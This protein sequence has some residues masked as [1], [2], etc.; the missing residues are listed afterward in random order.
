MFFIIKIFIETCYKRE[1][2]ETCYHA[3]VFSLIENGQFSQ[4]R[5]QEVMKKMVPCELMSLCENYQFS[6]H[7]PQEVMQKIVPC[8][9][10]SSMKMANFLNIAPER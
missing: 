8:E 1:K 6:Q 3:N 4:H 5:P 2:E 7:R 10:I 9:R